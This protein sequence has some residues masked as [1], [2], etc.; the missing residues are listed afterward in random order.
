MQE[1]MLNGK[2]L[3]AV[4]MDDFMAKRLLLGAAPL[5][6]D[7]GSGA[8][9][10]GDTPDTQ[11][12]T[13]QDAASAVSAVGSVDA[14]QSVSQHAEDAQI[15][16]VTRSGSWLDSL[17]D[18]THN[19]QD[20][21]LA[22]PSP[23]VEVIDSDVVSVDRE[24]VNGRRANE[25][26]DGGVVEETDVSVG[27]ASDTDEGLVDLGCPL[28]TDVSGCSVLIAQIQIDESLSSCRELATK[29]LNSY[30]WSKGLLL[31]R[32]V[33]EMDV[34]VDRIV[35]PG[36]R[37][38]KVLGLAHDR[39]GHTGV[40]GMRR[41]LQPKFTWPGIHGDIV[42]YVKSCDV[43]LKFN[44]AGNRAAKMVERPIV[45]VPFE[46]VAIDIV[47]PLPKARRGVRYLFTY[48]CL[49]S[50]WP[51]A[52][53]MRTAS[54]N[55][56]AECFV[57]VIS[58][59]GIPL[60]VLSDRGSVFLGRVIGRVCE[61]LGI[62][63]VVTSPYRPQSNGVVERMHGT[64]KPMLAKAIERDLDWSEFLPLALF[65]IRQVPNRD[66]GFSPHQLVYG[67]NVLGPLDL[68][69]SGWVDEKFERVDVE[70]WVLKLQDKLLLLHDLAVAH[71][72]DSASKRCLSF[73]R[74]KSDRCLEVGSKVLV[75]IPGLHAS[76]QASWEGPYVV[77]DRVSRVTYRISKGEGHPVKLVHLNNTKVYKDRCAW[78]NAVSVVAEE[79][80]I[81]D[82]LDGSKAVLGSEKCVGYR[83]SD[84]LT[85]VSSA[86]EFFSDV[87]GL[88]K[89]GKCSI[90][91]SDGADVV[92]LQP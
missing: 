28:P 77:Q 92:N 38:K 64:L 60:K 23:L 52:C 59:T 86:E 1:G 22:N 34:C 53:P 33:D 83:E 91:L 72:T 49:A 67:R 25:V 14:Q 48:V 63:Q 32:I 56:V 87:P 85:V 70:E 30:K 84:L 3:F 54:A 11:S 46:S 29:G 62:D 9:H 41:L 18:E 24:E 27:V 45:S 5:P 50:R 88:C 26:A 42:E 89:V 68:L 2:V 90:K 79:Q 65:A 81:S 76:L 15:S 57:D 40:R 66:V 20:E 44:K 16:V 75:R 74:N 7:Q 31:H 10:S 51:E 43:C 36:A 73:N 6:D 19:R 61:M 69:Y 80:G 55:E 47:G 13:E 39:C 8:G 71:E 21:V 17:S 35:V 58:R 4:P 78:V 37:R 12:S 82:D